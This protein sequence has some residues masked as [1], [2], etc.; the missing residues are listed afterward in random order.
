MCSCANV[1]LKTVRFETDLPYQSM[2]LGSLEV[3]GSVEWVEPGIQEELCPLAV[4]QNKASGRHALLVLRQH[5]VHVVSLEVRERLD[6]AVR[7][8]DRSVLNHEFL[9]LLGTHDLLLNLELWRHDKRIL[10]EI[11]E[12]SAVWKLGHR[13]SHGDNLR[14]RLWRASRVI[15]TVL[16]KEYPVALRIAS[17]TCCSPSRDASLRTILFCILDSVLFLKRDVLGTASGFVEDR[18]DY[19]RRVS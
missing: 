16:R 1:S 10:L 7:R 8:N 11:P 15:I 4:P 9:E 19:H 5:K 18:D 3:V 12:I 17:V 6:D 2:C 13:M 14:P